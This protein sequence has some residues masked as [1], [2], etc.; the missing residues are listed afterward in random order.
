M[1]ERY[2]LFSQAQSHLKEEKTA[3]LLTLEHITARYVMKKI[4]WRTSTEKQRNKIQG[5]IKMTTTYGHDVQT[6]Y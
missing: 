6:R 4:N 1:A 2:Q 3:I 5:S